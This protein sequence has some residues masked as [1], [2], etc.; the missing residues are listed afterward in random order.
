MK[1]LR[2]FCPGNRGLDEILELER[3]ARSGAR[4][5]RNTAGQGPAVRVGLD[6][7]GGNWEALGYPGA[8]AP[9]GEG[10]GSR[11][12]GRGSRVPRSRTFIRECCT[13]R[14]GSSP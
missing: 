14:P 2:T 6:P 3:V 7:E 4:V 12:A 13:K 9:G 11:V 10:R 5:D 8:R 1:F